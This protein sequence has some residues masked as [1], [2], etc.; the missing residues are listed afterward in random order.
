MKAMNAITYVTLGEREREREREIENGMKIVPYG[1]A[2]FY[3]QPFLRT[4]RITFRGNRA[5]IRKFK[6]RKWLA[7]KMFENDSNCSQIV[8]VE[9]KKNIFK[10]RE[11]FFF[12]FLFT[13]NAH[14]DSEIHP[15]QSV[16]CQRHC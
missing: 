4:R 6:S 8:V 3:L 9:G 2:S 15:F 11:S 12:F 5:E 13:W 10:I 16:S 1:V 14:F 7:L